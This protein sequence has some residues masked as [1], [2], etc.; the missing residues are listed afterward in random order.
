MTHPTM[1]PVPK[2]ED[3][4]R[5]LV[6]LGISAIATSL[7]P[8][9]I[10]LSGSTGAPMT[11]GAGFLV[12]YTL[13][14]HASRYTNRALR[15]IPYSQ[16][17]RRCRDEYVPTGQIVILLV[18]MMIGAFGYVAFSWSTRYIDTAVSSSLFELWPV[19]WILV[20][21]FVDRRRH[22]KQEYRIVPLSTILLMALGTGAITLVIFS[23]ANPATGQTGIELPIFGVSLGLLA[24][25]LGAFAAFNYLLVDR[26]MFGKAHRQDDDW[27]ILESSRHQKGIEESVI[28]SGVVLAR[29][30]A[31]PIVLILAVLEVGITSA[32]VSR[33]FIGGMLC[34]FVLNGPAG[35]LVRRA[36]VISSR[37]EIISLQYLSPV[38]ALA[39]LAVLTDIDVH[40]LD[41]LIF[42]TVSIV[43][44]NMLINADPERK[45][46]SKVIDA[47]ESDD[48]KVGTIQERYSLKALVVSLL[49]FGMLVYFRDELL[50]EADL[51]WSETGNYWAVL[52]LA[53]TVFALLLAFRLTRVESLLL[54]EDHRTLGLARRIEAL[55]DEV[56]VVD[57][58]LSDLVATQDPKSSLLTWVR[59][60]NRAVRLHQYRSAYTKANRLLE[61]I[62]VVHSR[63]SSVF[64]H[65][66]NSQLVEI[67]TELDALAHGR[68]QAREFAERVAL[69]LIGV[70]I[71][72][73]C[74]A[75][76]IE[77]AGLARLLS[78]IFVTMLASIV[79]YLL[80]HLADMRRSRADELLVGYDEGEP[81]R[82]RDGFSVRF[83]DEK[84]AQW[85]RIFAGI[86]I[87][88]VVVT[89]VALL[90]WARLNAG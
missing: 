79:V 72:A 86:I 53:S 77:E 48:E 42:G 33:Q 62:K 73:V 60:L 75:V 6:L 8:V 40:R 74:L 30:F 35:F 57:S 3:T 27:D 83:R 85:Q 68:Q 36:N 16:I 84:D 18:I 44:L 87:L 9:S 37:R 46:S 26:L 13:F 59:E 41:F 21:Q 69:W 65:E 24:P 47:L 70:T 1:D 12:G 61:S 23:T 63:N 66:V 52:G 17:L 45:K 25:I 29:I 7:I 90:A 5:A 31:V 54:A 34:G 10:E 32:F 28:H 19:A 43:A 50:A 64:S 22:G 89:V 88:G 15:P 2:A 20:F 76:P 82:L 71:I 4:T 80:F 49:L 38:L 67:R 55:P 14:T 56:L 51:S 78:E 58:E 11:V 39:W 81:D